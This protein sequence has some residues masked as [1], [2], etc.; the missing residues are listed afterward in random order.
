MSMLNTPFES[1]VVVYL[2]FLILSDRREKKECVLSVPFN[3]A[4]HLSPLQQ[5][6]YIAEIRQ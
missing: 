5:N 1:N 2:Q 6:F 3:I 4:N